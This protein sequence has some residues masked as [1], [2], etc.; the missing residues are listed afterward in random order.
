MTT[1]EVLF[2]P[3]PEIRRRSG[4]HHAPLGLVAGP[5]VLRLAGPVV[6]AFALIARAGNTPQ[7][8][9]V[10]LRLH[11]GTFSP[12]LSQTIVPHR[13][14]RRWRNA[15][16]L[17]LIFLEALAQF[18]FPQARNR[19]G[20]ARGRF[21]DEARDGLRGVRPAEAAR[22]FAHGS[23]ARWIVEQPAQ[24]VIEDGD[25][26]ALDGGSSL[27]QHIRI[28]LLLSADWIEDHHRQAAGERLRGGQPARLA[29][30]ERGRAKQIGHLVRVTEHAKTVPLLD[31]QRFDFLL[32]FLIFSTDNDGLEFPVE[33]QQPANDCRGRTEAEGSTGDEQRWFFR[34]ESVAT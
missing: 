19:C 29:Q 26:R 14:R 32:Q 24:L 15:H 25:L 30:Q 8:F 6:T 2:V 27:Q 1:G 21:Q 4:A 31:R 11:F 18:L 16:F 20:L 10:H 7:E 17:P 13:T 3:I 5:I 34:V 22:V 28:T 23:D 12:A 33:L 9:P